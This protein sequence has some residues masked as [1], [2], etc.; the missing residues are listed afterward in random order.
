MFWRIFYLPNRFARFLFFTRHFDVVLAYYFL[1]LLK[2][3][4][5]IDKENL[6]DSDST[7]YNL[8][9]LLGGKEPPPPLDLVHVQLNRYL[10]TG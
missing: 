10:I 4:F 9:L 7:S 1:P 6:T 8:E 3:G 2:Q 5:N